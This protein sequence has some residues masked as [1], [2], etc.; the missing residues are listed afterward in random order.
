MIAM[1]RRA[2]RCRSIS[3]I[4][5]D[6]HGRDRNGLAA[7]QRDGGGLD[8]GHGDVRERRRDRRRSGDGS[9]G[10]AGRV[11]CEIGGHGASR[12]EAEVAEGTGEERRGRGVVVSATGGYRR[13]VFGF[14]M[15]QSIGFDVLPQH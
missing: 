11:G 2:F 9:V 13:H 7:G 15:Q 8:G 5:D 12:G 6:D 3:R 4:F 14:G 1:N 10:I